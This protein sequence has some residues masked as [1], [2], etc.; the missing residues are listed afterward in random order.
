MHAYSVP[1][2]EEWWKMYIVYPKERKE[3]WKKEKQLHNCILFSYF[4]TDA[5]AEKKREEWKLAAK[6]KGERHRE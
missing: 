6:K 4:V 1:G 5:G 3:Y 2:K